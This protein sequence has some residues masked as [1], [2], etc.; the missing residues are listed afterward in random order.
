VTSGILF[1]HAWVLLLG[2]K[3]RSLAGWV[4]LALLTSMLWVLAGMLYSMLIARGVTRGQSWNIVVGTTSQLVFIRVHGV[5][6]TADA[7]LLNVLP[8]A[9]QFFVQVLLLVR[10]VADE[11]AWPESLRSAPLRQVP[12][13]RDGHLDPQD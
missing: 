6:D 2:A 4:P 8:A 12:S 3:Y 5:Y 7:V 9:S 13:T 10:T 1:P 11:S